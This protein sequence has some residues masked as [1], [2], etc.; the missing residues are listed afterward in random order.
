MPLT[1]GQTI[2][3]LHASLREYIE[4][5]YHISKPSLIRQR[6][7][8]LNDDGVI[9][10][11]PYLESTPRYKVGPRFRELGLPAA[12]LDLFEQLSAEN[13]N[14]GRVLHDPPWEHQAS[15][16]QSAI[17]NGQSLL[18]ATGTGS[19]KTECF[20]LP[21]LA[22]LANEASSKGEEFGHQSAIRALVMYPMN[23]LVND[24]LARLRSMLGDQ[25]VVEQ[26]MSWSGRA[27]RFARYTSRTLYPGVRTKAKDQK[28]LPVIDKFYLEYLRSSRGDPSDEQERADKLV[29]TLRDRGKWPAKHDLQAWFGCKGK[30]WQ[31]SAGEFQRCLT[32]PR[33]AELFTRHEVHEA[34]PDILVTNYSMLEY[35]LMRPLERPVF[36]RTS[37]W[38]REN[39]DLPFLLVIDEAHLYRGAAGAEVALLVRRLRSR[40]NIPPERLQVICTSASFEDA[41]Y[42]IEFA[43]QL[44][45]KNVQDFA[46]PIKGSLEYRQEESTGDAGDVDALASIDLDKFYTTYENRASTVREFL[47]SRG[48]SNHEGPLEQA[49]YDALVSYG[50]IGLLINRTMDEA[51]PV[52]ELASLLFINCDSQAADQAVTSLIA[53]GSFARRTPNE[54]GLLPCRVHAFYRGLAGLWAC[55]DPDCSAIPEDLRDGVA[56]KLYAQP[57]D[58]CSCGSRVLELFTCR[59]CGSAYA[60]AYTSELDEPH[61][62]WA[63]PG[64]EFRSLVGVPEKLEPLDLLIEREPIIEREN[65]EPHTYDIVTGQLD[66]KGEASLSRTIFLRRDRNAADGESVERQNSGPGQ[67]RPC[68]VCGQNAD[69]GRSH[70]SSVQ[71]HQTKGDQPFQALI[72]KQIQVQ[73]PGPTAET[74]FAPLRGRKVLVFSDSRQ[75]AARLAPNLQKYSMQDA[76]RSLLMCGYDILLRSETLSKNLNLSQAYFAVLL[77]AAEMGIRLRPPLTGSESFIGASEVRDAVERGAL[78]DDQE[79]LLV[80]GRVNSTNPPESILDAI[81]SCITDRYYGLESLGLA[82]ISETAYGYG[83]DVVEN[84]PNIPGVAETVE[85]KTALLRLWLRAWVQKKGFFLSSMPVAWMD[86]KVQT[87]TGNFR[88]VQRFLGTAVAKRIFKEQWLHSLLQVFGEAVIGNKFRLRGAELTLNLEGAW[89]YCNICCTTQ[90]PFPDLAKCINCGES[91]VR[92]IDPDTDPAFRSRKA[93][94]RRSTVEA[95]RSDDRKNP[96]ALVAAE[97]TAQLNASRS[98]DVFSTAEMYELLFQD[99]DLGPDDAG[100]DRAAVDI[101]SCTTTMEVGIDIG[102]LSGVSL[103]NLPPARANYQQRAGRRGTSVVTVMAFASADSHDEHYFSKPDEMIRGAVDDPRLTLDNVDIIRRHVTAYLL[104]LYHRARLPDIPPEGQRQLFEVLGT[105]A[106][107]LNSTSILNRWDFLEWLQENENELR[108][109]IASWLPDEL[110]IDA[111][112]KLLSNLVQ[113]TEQELNKALGQGQVAEETVQTI[114]TDIALEVRLE[115]GEERPP[116]TPD[117]KNLLDRLLYKGVLPRYAFPTDVATFHVFAPHS[118]EIRPDFLYTPSQ[119]LPIALSQYAP[120]KEVWIDNKLWQSGAIYSPVREDLFDMWNDR[121]IY[122]ECQQCHYAKTFSTEQASRGDVR[123]CEACGAEDRFGPAKY[124][125][126]PPGFAHR[127]SVEEGTTPDDQAPRSYAT[128]AKLM[129]PTPGIDKP[130]QQIN[131]RVKSFHLRDHLLVTNRGPQEEGYNYCTTCG[132][133]DPCAMRNAVVLGAHRKPY[134]TNRNDACVDGHVAR[135]IVLGTDFLSDVL[136]VSIEVDDPIRLRPGDLITDVALRTVSEAISTAACRKLDLESRELQSEYRPA[137]SLAGQAGR[138]AEIF[139]YDTTPGGAGFSKSAGEKGR[140][141]LELAL[142]ILD[143]CPESC[144][145]S[146]YRCLRSYKNKFEHEL[147]DRHIGASLIRHLLDGTS[148]SLKEERIRQSTN[149]IFEDL[150]RLELEIEVECD[151]EISM[152]GLPTTT[153][154]ILVSR[155]DGRRFIIGVN[156]SLTPGVF[157]DESL[158]EWAELSTGFSFLTADDLTIRRNLPYATKDIISR[159]GLT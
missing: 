92:I 95:R 11:R 88:D 83:H 4:A 98:D 15:A 9:H 93:F 31:N 127:V 90:R 18:V 7:R 66:P 57:R 55:M 22:K 58:I 36:E 130:W 76:M 123:D 48:I 155:P 84:L 148:P 108:E 101:L 105:V 75:T 43:A 28:N 65:C 156:N 67:F 152:Q 143:T 47:E 111:R 64:G 116:V 53:L 59:H 70:R 44:T 122:F 69:Y 147:L 45:G 40:L 136:L 63:E 134:P 13:S 87:S 1:I 38:L 52:G 107:F 16:L 77:A 42:A 158:W 115:E 159:M 102:A 99:I 139:L 17:L 145:R 30:H 97:H 129:A 72:S 35:M 118:N 71:D 86:N 29:K 46:D 79:L 12:T 137:V 138:E 5:T 6:R 14:Y 68:A 114:E 91:N 119:G 113:G 106:E 112:G 110:D 3:E 74:L 39:P 128:R 73:A 34:P 26:F 2:D 132:L 154:P 27:A 96:M 117:N 104:Q 121:L 120:G 131:K 153:A 89:V 124:W 82:S 23:A 144:D 49:V 41:D 81:I 80:Q 146:C 56:G 32:M 20:L 157:A 78:Q 8:L 103:R 33:D 19:G 150:R 54:P 140:E 21:I 142:T 60:R 62:L 135:G 94:Y 151:I 37:S 125:V 100:C 133:I 149:L 24:Q 109:G 85:Q 10:Q 61:Y 126:R 25:R 141:I 51:L 50:P